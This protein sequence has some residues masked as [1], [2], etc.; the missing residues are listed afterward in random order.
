MLT[1]IIDQHTRLLSEAEFAWLVLGDIDHI[2]LALLQ[3]ALE[4]ALLLT[5]GQRLVCIV[6]GDVNGQ[7]FALLVVVV[8]ALVLVEL[9][10]TV[11][12]SIHIERNLVSRFLIA[13]LHLGTIGDDAAL[14]DIDRNALVGSVNHQR[15]TT[16]DILT[17]IQVVPT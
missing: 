14:T 1:T 10:L 2:E 12:T 7:I 4:L 16:L 8:H 9:E 6:V 5:D 13:V 11:A 3:R 17:R 15:L